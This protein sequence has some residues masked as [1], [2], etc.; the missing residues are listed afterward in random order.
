MHRATLKIIRVSTIDLV[1]A[2]SRN[3][4]PNNCVVSSG[5]ALCR[6]L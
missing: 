4:L 1:M 3:D 6:G 5:V 2:G